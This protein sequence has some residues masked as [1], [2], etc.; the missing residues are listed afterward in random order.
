MRLPL[1][2]G[3]TESARGREARD[4]SR[5]PRG[6]SRTEARGVSGV[7]DTALL[8]QVPLLRCKKTVVSCDQFTTRHGQRTDAVGE[9][10]PT[11]RLSRTREPV[12]G[13]G[14]DRGRWSGTERPRG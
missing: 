5:E 9:R 1:P 3:W 7:E 6:E 2:H 4:E 10:H 14:G 13:T 12:L 11:H 8:G